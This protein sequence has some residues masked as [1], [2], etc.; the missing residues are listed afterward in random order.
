MENREWE[1][2]ASLALLYLANVAVILIV[3]SL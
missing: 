1:Q 2:L 3:Q